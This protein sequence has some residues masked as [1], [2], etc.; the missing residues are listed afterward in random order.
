[1]IKNIS[2]EEMSK[3]LQNVAQSNILKEIMVKC[4]NLKLSKTEIYNFFFK[5]LIHYA[6]STGD[7]SKLSIN[8]LGIKFKNNLDMLTIKKYSNGIDIQKENI[9]S[10]IVVPEILNYW[11][12][13]LKIKQPISFK[14]L[15]TILIQIKEQNLKNSFK[16]HSFNGAL[17]EQ[18]RE[19][20]LNI[21]QE[22]FSTE[23]SILSEISDTPYQK[24]ILFEC[25]L[26]QASIGYLHKSPE[27]MWMILGKYFTGKQEDNESDRD[28]AYRLL[29]NLLEKTNATKDKKQQYFQAGKKIIDFYTSSPKRCIAV[30]K[31]ELLN[32]SVDSF[33]IN[34]I[35]LTHIKTAFLKLPS[36]LLSNLT[37]EEKNEF[38]AILN[39]QTSE[40]KF[41]TIENKLKTLFDKC[42]LDKTF[43]NT[44]KKTGF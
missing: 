35:L 37:K 25:E 27:K 22:K 39:D 44:I 23:F 12:N 4:N 8:N 33:F 26:S 31:E 3:F 43:I 2:Q 16:T 11:T 19:N 17:E 7:L 24:G 32:I 41:D 40:N 21:K 34:K 18:I 36:K 42:G 29:N 28:F 20:G 13:S 14:D 10:D 1:M 5:S 38:L 9:M 6:L 30:R 15:S